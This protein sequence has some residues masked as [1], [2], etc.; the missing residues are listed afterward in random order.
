MNGSIKM[1]LCYIL[2]KATSL[3]ALNATIT[4]ADN[5]IV[6]DAISS[7]INQ[8]PVENLKATIT[9]IDN[10]YAELVLN[11][12]IKGDLSPIVDIAMSHSQS[13]KLAI[14]DLKDT[15]ML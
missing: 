5:T 11:G 12:E 3:D 8:T 6:I 9:N 1:H 15:L 13:R 2:K 4:L 10:S 7:Q 14:K